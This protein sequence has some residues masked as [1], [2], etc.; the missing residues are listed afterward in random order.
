[1]KIYT[2]LA[3]AYLAVPLSSG[4]RLESGNQTLRYLRRRWKWRCV[5][6]VRLARLNCPDGFGTC[7]AAQV[8]ATGPIVLIHVRKSSFQC[9][10]WNNRTVLTI[11]LMLSYRFGKHFC[12][13]P[14]TCF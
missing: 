8:A 11:R 4:Q 7:L 14:L 10:G 2:A 13:T 1:M 5:C 12:H 3:S 6:G 9:Y